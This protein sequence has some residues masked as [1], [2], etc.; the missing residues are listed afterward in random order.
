MYLS[1]RSAVLSTALAFGLLVL[2][3]LSEVHAVVVPYL[4][5]GSVS[6]KEPLDARHAITVLVVYGLLFV[7]TL[8]LLTTLSRMLRRGEGELR[9]THEEVTRL[10]NQRRDF[11]HIAVHNLRSPIGVTTMF[12]EHLRAG[13][14]GPITEQQQKWL[15]TCLR[16]L[17]GLQVFLQDLQLLSTFEAG[18]LEAK[19]TDV[20]MAALLRQIV[21]EHREL[22]SRNEH[23]L[24]L[25]LPDD[26]PPVRGIERLL[27]EAIV[28]YVSNAIKYTP[29]GGH[30]VV[31]AV[32]DGGLLRVEVED[33]GIGIADSDRDRLFT[34][35]F[36]GR[37]EETPVAG[38]EGTGLGLSIVKRIAGVH[39]GRVDVRSEVDRGS[40]FVLEIPFGPSA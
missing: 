36:R 21:D 1:T 2:L 6:S 14:G 16:R 27:R 10:S 33:D 4:P 35:F 5:I 19:K 26:L 28:N 9:R 8:F 15:D 17:D 23:E 20:D 22:A 18:E 34:E 29:N 31:R 12:V 40:T 25:V 7:M 24:K 37:R 39:G 11:L 30:I 13:L 38:V 32:R 3:A